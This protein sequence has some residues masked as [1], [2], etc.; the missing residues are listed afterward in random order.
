MPA[1]SDTPLVSCV[2]PTF[3]AGRYLAQALESIRD[4][5]HATLEIVIADDGSDDD[6]LDIV[7]GQGDG[8][9]LVAHREQGPAATRN[10][11]IRAA[12]GAFL[13]FLDPDD[14]WHP[15][16]LARQVQAFQD[17]PRLDLCVSHVR[18]FWEGA[19][20]E[21]GTR[22]KEHARA[23]QP[24]PGF[25]ATTLLARRS[26]FD[27]IGLF[28]PDLWFADGVDWFLRAEA[29]GLQR[30][31]L[32]DVLT[33]HRMHEGNLTRRRSR[34]SRDEFLRVVKAWSDRRRG[35][36]TEARG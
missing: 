33:Y 36:R 13:A 26:A 8:V 7:R 30:R 34:D 2:V 29:A 5:R 20:A 32:P 35:N 27:R 31:L 6:T 11:G 22:L 19:V 23:T 14:L 28:D 16:K 4:Q 17:E 12:R 1:T 21:E 10:L 3:N 15:D 25:A 18:M 24:V 9:R